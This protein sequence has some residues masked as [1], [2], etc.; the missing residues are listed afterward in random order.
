MSARVSARL[1]GA[2]AGVTDAARWEPSALRFLEEAQENARRRHPADGGPPEAAAGAPEASPIATA[3][4]LGQQ[5]RKK[6]QPKYLRAACLDASLSLPLARGVKPAKPPPPP[7]L[8]LEEGPPALWVVE[9]PATV[10]VSTDG[11]TWHIPGRAWL[12]LDLAAPGAPEDGTAG[13]RALCPGAGGG[14]ILETGGAALL[15]RV[16]ED[17]LTAKAAEANL[18][19]ALRG[20]SVVA[21]K[22]AALIAKEVGQRSGSAEAAAPD[23]EGREPLHAPRTCRELAREADEWA[24]R[25]EGIVAFREAH[26]PL[27]DEAWEPRSARAGLAPA[28]ERGARSTGLRKGLQALQDFTKF[29]QERYGNPLR[30]WM[31][32]NPEATQGIGE[33]QFARGLERIGF[34]GNAVALWRYID[35]DS[36]GQITLVELA[37]RAA[38]LL[39]ELKKIIVSH[40]GPAAKLRPSVRDATERSGSN[41]PAPSIRSRSKEETISVYEVMRQLDG[42]NSGH[43]HRAEFIEGLQ[44]MGYS[45]PAGRIF[46]M[47]VEQGASFLKPEDFAFLDRWHLPLY[48][49]VAA[50]KGAAEELKESLKRGHKSLFEAWI[51]VLDPDRTMRV[52]WHEFL[53]FCTK[54]ARDKKSPAGLDDEAHV[55][56]IWRAMDDDCSGWIAM[57]EL[58]PDVF[59]AVATVKRWGMSVGGVSR[60]LRELALREMAEEASEEWAFD[61]LDRER[62]LRE[63]EIRSNVTKE[64]KMS[65]QRFR[66][67]LFKYAGIRKDVSYVLFE[68]LEHGDHFVSNSDLL[69][70]D[71]WDL[72]LEELEIA[73][74]RMRP[75]DRRRSSGRRNP[76]Q[77][78]GKAA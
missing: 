3:A 8:P 12:A 67:I 4:P 73:M 70:L 16:S 30:A 9:S 76:A 10:E 69:F 71:K 25:M 28:D 68:A 50:D 7:Q 17:R 62:A 65:K 52:C 56:A 34:R 55:A 59:E 14:C 31:A 1:R 45:G 43:I 38:R 61:S 13:G 44:S 21:L 36:S 18:R 24:A 63:L 58:D 74:S 15:R 19:R 29:T 57:R 20:S 39:A 26:R 27:A 42:N 2:G 46:D 22:H 72:E 5:G 23:P 6:V 54:A 78:L 47:I 40:A 33:K 32:L 53:A 51:K 37:P 35:R 48:L 66:E 11:G 41:S 77:A 64:V 75:T 49:C 60:G